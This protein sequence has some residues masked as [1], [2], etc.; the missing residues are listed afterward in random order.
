MLRISKDGK[1]RPATVSARSPGSWSDGLR[2]SATLAST[3]LVPI[4]ATLPNFFASKA[5][6]P[7]IDVAARAQDD[8]VSG[9]LI[10]L[11]FRPPALGSPLAAAG[12]R[13]ATFVVDHVDDPASVA[14]GEATQRVYLRQRADGTT[15]FLTRPPQIDVD[16]V[17]TA[18]LDSGEQVEATLKGL[19]GADGTYT[20]LLAASLGDA[21]PPG[22]M[23][24]VDFGV[25]RLWLTVTSAGASPPVGSPGQLAVLVEG[26]GLFVDPHPGAVVWPY[27]LDVERLQLKLWTWQGDATPVVLDRLGFD[28]AHPRAAWALPSDEELFRGADDAIDTDARSIELR[29]RADELAP[30]WADAASPQFDLSPRFDLTVPDD[31]GVTYLPVGMPYVPEFELGPEPAK[32]TT[33]D[34]DGLATFD[35]SLFLDPALATT[36]VADLLNEADFLRYQSPVPRRLKGIHAALGVDEATVIAVPD[37][38]LPGWSQD[39][40]PQAP[41]GAPA[42]PKNPGSDG[43][44]L[45]CGVNALTLPAIELSVPDENGTFTLRWSPVAGADRYELQESADPQFGSGVTSSFTTG[46]QLVVYGHSPGVFYVRARALAGALDSG[47]SAAMTLSIATDAGWVMRDEPTGSPA[48]ATSPAPALRPVQGALLR[49]CAARGDL[50]ALLSLPL[51]HSA[52]E[53]ARYIATLCADAD[54]KTLSFGAAYHPW[55]VV[56]AAPADPLRTTPPEGAIA[57]IY[58]RRSIARGA[59]VAP[60]NEPLASM[61]LGLSPAFSDDVWAILD[62]Q[63]VNRI[64]EEAHGLLA[65]SADTLTGD[66]DLSP[67]SVRRLLMLLRR[68][69]LSL[70]ATYVFE[71]NDDRLARVVDSTFTSLLDGLFRRGA[72]AGATADQSYR[73][74]TDSSVNPPDSMDLGRFVV[75][76]QVAPSQ[77]LTF[78]TVRLVQTAGQLAAGGS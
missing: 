30:L 4:D 60:A 11:T 29:R 21:P 8:L 49:M 13:V 7:S 77:P 45:P 22:G 32:G 27:G 25:W 74:V 55:I 12:V 33:L 63:P 53:A 64:R 3:A 36:D 69:A 46:T 6:K 31:P 19:S 72:F 24:P 59:W 9:D 17:G 61:V 47:W 23:L 65:M 48:V 50:F 66:P 20:L 26:K 39:E 34:R 41:P 5:E 16:T 42:E 38:T 62:A 10:R 67:I 75:E 71:P 57:G 28:P 68:A 73:V 15:W 51:S 70:G 40:P 35:S 54:D 78:L 37:A 44:F 14:S 76:L 18:T 1:W 58:A 56:R 52:E 2:V 43:S